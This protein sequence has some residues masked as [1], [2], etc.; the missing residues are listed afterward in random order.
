[1]VEVTREVLRDDG[2]TIAGNLRGATHRGMSRQA[3]EAD[4]AATEMHGTRTPV[5]WPDRLVVVAVRSRMGGMPFRQDV[6]GVLE[7]LADCRDQ[8]PQN[9]RRERCCEDTL[10]Q[11]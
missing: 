2:Q 4:T 5:L 3:A 10:H 9:E 8:S 1:M 7:E 6:H 11:I